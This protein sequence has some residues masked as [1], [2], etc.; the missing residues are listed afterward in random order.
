MV[1]EGQGM[2]GD[3]LN[4]REE[5]EA[6]RARVAALEGALREG[7]AQLQDWI[8]S[9]PDDVDDN[10]HKVCGLI[11]KELRAA[12]A[13]SQNISQSDVPLKSTIVTP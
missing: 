8:D 12:L 2:L 4:L 13:D 10:D 3:I 5:N 9:F 11:D 7:R 6:L 1:I